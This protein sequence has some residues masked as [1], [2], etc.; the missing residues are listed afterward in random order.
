MFKN[1]KNKSNPAIYYDNKNFISYG[2]LLN[3]SNLIKKKIKEN[4]LVIFLI[5]NSAQSLMFYYSL[6]NHDVSVLLLE[7]NIDQINLD[8]FIKRYRPKYILLECQNKKTIKK[9]YIK[10][11]IENILLYE[12]LEKKIQYSL[13]N[14][15]K[16]I[17][18]TS[19]SSG[20]PKC[21]K[22]SKKNLETNTNAI[23][24][25]LNLTEKDKT[26]TTLPP[27]YS[28]GLSI[29]NTHFYVGG[30]IISNSFSLYQKNFWELI[31][32]SK[33]SNI[34]GVPFFYEI[35]NKIG[36]NKIKGLKFF[37]QAG[38]SLED[39]LFIDIINYLKKTNINLFLMYGQ[40][41]ASPRMSYCKINKNNFKN[42]TKPSIGKVILDGKIILKDE[43]GFHINKPFTEGEIIY[44]GP[45]IFCGYSKNF[46]DLSKL[47]KNKKLST[48]D[49]AYYDQ[50]K[51][52]F[53]V[54]RK[55]RIAKLYGIRYDLNEIEN[56]IKK[57][58]GILS[59]C[60]N[61][62]NKI[63]I[64]SEKKINIYKINNIPTSSLVFKKLIKIP[65]LS[66]GKVDIVKLNNKIN[67]K[68]KKKQ[69]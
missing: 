23:I 63:Y 6:I 2:D 64:F 38:G 45:N 15:L 31:D 17:L 60:V 21:V 49:I 53:I 68:Y 10:E 30:S 46:K 29:L 34:N 7:S 1:V 51:N 3:F 18:T 48:G 25:Y 40:T 24:N 55:N 42:F 56:D 61:Y 20:D 39:K 57:K 58:T 37:T 19:G 59:I 52:Y 11:K 47:E 44:E 22:I 14:N 54:G 32:E 65:R 5:N 41:E 50:N 62:K 43:Y 36:L 66:N 27:S 13:N 16:L 4:S 8:K 69:I 35:L 67:D 28:Y 26:I 12:N 33:I 9:F